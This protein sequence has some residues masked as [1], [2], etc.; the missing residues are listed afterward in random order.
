[1]SIGDTTDSYIGEPATNA[2]LDNRYVRGPSSATDHNIPQFNGTTGKLIE[3]SGLSL[4]TDGTLAANSDSRLASQKATK[5]YAD[6][7]HAIGFAAKN[8]AGTSIAGDGAV[9]QVPFATEDYDY[10]GGWVTDTFTVPA[11][12][13]GVYEFNIGVTLTSHAIASGEQFALFLKVDATEVRTFFFQAQ[14]SVS[15]YN[16]IRGSCKL[17]LTA[18]QTVKAYIYNGHVGSAIAL[19]AAANYNYFDGHL[20][21]RV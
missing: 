21:Y 11:G 1:V 9:T 8:S 10:G 14:A 15:I 2:S 16:Q 7:Y 20:L 6:N 19:Y 5:T 17:K 12:A 4:D 18:G 3:D 13:G